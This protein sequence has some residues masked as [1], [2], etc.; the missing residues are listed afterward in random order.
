MGAG[1]AFIMPATLSIIM[2]V[3]TDHAERT[4]AIGP[5]A[6]GWLLAHF[7]WDSIFLVN[8]PIVAVAL[9]LGYWLVPAS[10]WGVFGQTSGRACPGDAGTGRGDRGAAALR[11]GV[12]LVRLRALRAGH[13]HRVGRDRAGHVG[14]HVGARFARRP[15][16]GR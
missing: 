9:I 6:G 8:L 16:R 14:G 4:K 3:F 7:S 15:L 12:R 11:Y 5:V 13:G 1:G 2:A 10:A